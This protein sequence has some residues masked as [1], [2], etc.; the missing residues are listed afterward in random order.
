MVGPAVAPLGCE[1]VVMAPISEAGLAVVRKHAVVI[2]AV[3]DVIAAGC[4]RAAAGISALLPV[5]VSVAEIG[6]EVMLAGDGA[7]VAAGLTGGIVFAEKSWASK[8]FVT[9]QP[10]CSQACQ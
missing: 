6:S 1:I 4:D 3:E 7:D 2:R 5:L 8:S 10:S 9:V